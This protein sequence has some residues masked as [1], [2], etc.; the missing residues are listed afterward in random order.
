MN[1]NDGPF[2][3]L[4]GRF[5]TKTQVCGPI[6]HRTDGLETMTLHFYAEVRSDHPLYQ[7]LVSLHRNPTQGLVAGFIINSLLN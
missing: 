4:S 2:S 7:L 1:P 5:E 6:P 3:P